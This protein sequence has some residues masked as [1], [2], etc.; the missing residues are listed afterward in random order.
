MGWQQS[1]AFKAAFS[2]DVDIEFLGV[3]CVSIFT[4]LLIYPDEFGFRDT[5]DSVG[6][7]PKRLPF[8]TSNTIVRTF[9][10]A[11]ALDERRA[12]FKAN[13]WNRPTVEEEQLGVQATTSK[14]IRGSPIPFIE[15]LSSRRDTDASH[16]RSLSR[17]KE[18]EEEQKL[19]NFEKQY[20]ERQ[21]HPTDVEEVWFSV[22][23]PGSFVT[24]ICIELTNVLALVG[25]SLRYVPC[26]RGSLQY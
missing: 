21:E 19:S 10:H 12:K 7:I 13:L 16:R 4:V 26:P 18:W 3:W 25:L 5:V 6:I 9:R 17:N 8:T 15:S 11:I 1:N 2:N 22:R 20:S 24:A 14:P 23:C